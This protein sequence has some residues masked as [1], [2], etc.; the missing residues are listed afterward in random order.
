MDSLNHLK[1]LIFYENKFKSGNDR[2]KRNKNKKD[3]Y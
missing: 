1:K 3:K 2:S